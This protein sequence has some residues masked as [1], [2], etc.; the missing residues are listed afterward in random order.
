MG[1]RYMVCEPLTGKTQ[2]TCDYGHAVLLREGAY[3]QLS[4]ADQLTAKVLGREPFI[5]E[6]A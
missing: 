1:Q 5:E 3:A 6:R 4:P 2:E